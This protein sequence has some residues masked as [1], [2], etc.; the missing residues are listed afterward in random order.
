MPMV[1]PTSPEVG[2]VFTSGGRS[3]V[4]NGST[5]DSPSATNVLQVPI[6]LDFIRAVNFT[7]VTSVSIGSNADPVF[8]SRYDNYKIIITS[9]GSSNTNRTW[10]LRLR[11]NTT[12]D[13]S[14]LYSLM[15]QGIDRVGNLINTTA[16]NTTSATITPNA[17]YGT[18]R[19]SSTF[20]LLSPFLPRTT[21]LHGSVVGVDAN[22]FFHQSFSTTFT[23]AASYNGF[24]LTNSSGNFVDGTIYIY[25]YR[26]A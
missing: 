25:G 7:G 17:F 3:W 11:A 5:W 22:H 10:T 15:S 16:V 4:W 9:L 8:S 20:D 14:A 12:D 6:G 13:A 18:E 23:T 1:F 19:L 26:N 24:T 2:Q 21:F